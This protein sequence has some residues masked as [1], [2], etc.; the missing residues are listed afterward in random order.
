M[1][2]YLQLPG[3]VD[4]Y[5]CAINRNFKSM[6]DRRD[7]IVW[8]VFWCITRREEGIFWASEVCWKFWGFHVKQRRSMR[9]P[10]VSTAA[11]R[12]AKVSRDLSS[13]T[14]NSVDT[15]ANNVSPN[16]QPLF[17]SWTATCWLA[18]A[19]LHITT[20]LTWLGVSRPVGRAECLYLDLM[21]MIKQHFRLVFWCTNHPVQYVNAL[22]RRLVYSLFLSQ[23]CIRVV[24][25]Q[26]WITQNFPCQESVESGLMVKSNSRAC[27]VRKL[28]CDRK[29]MSKFCSKGRY[30][31][32]S[33]LICRQ[34]R[35]SF[36][37]ALLCNKSKR[38]W[39]QESFD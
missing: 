1:T 6:F 2:S 26:S 30:S 31:H 37:G 32:H 33:L 15:A 9:F 14:P 4:L 39:E 7:T 19:C 34:E 25:N 29:T 27:R 12:R 11:F 22:F 13:N 10:L 18:R 24:S 21:I 38:M 16:P 3:S 35:C 5:F 20:Y 28:K 36:T 23:F 8:L 17:N